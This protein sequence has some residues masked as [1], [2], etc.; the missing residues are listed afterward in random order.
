M[1]VQSDQVHPLPKPPALSLSLEG[2]EQ[3]KAAGG[4][5]KK[6]GTDTSHCV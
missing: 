1:E 6:V 4:L 3:R 2:P 5:G